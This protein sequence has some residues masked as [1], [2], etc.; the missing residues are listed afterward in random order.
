MHDFCQ[1]LSVFSEGVGVRKQRHCGYSVDGRKLRD[2]RHFF[3]LEEKIYYFVSLLSLRTILHRII[4]RRAFT[5][6][7][8]VS[9]CERLPSP[10]AGAFDAGE[11]YS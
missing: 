6:L 5:P 10:C 9:Q 11:S 2:F 8:N 4:Y 7:L 1:R 3:S